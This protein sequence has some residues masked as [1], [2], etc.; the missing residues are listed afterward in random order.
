MASVAQ[1]D[2]SVATGNRALSTPCL[3]TD[4]GLRAPV[5][6]V[7]SAYVVGSLDVDE[8]DRLLRARV[9][10]WV[11]FAVMIVVAVALGRTLE[12]PHPWPMLAAML[13][14]LGGGLLQPADP[15]ARRI[16]FRGRER[17]LLVLGAG[18]ILVSVIAMFRF[19]TLE[20][21]GGG[22]LALGLLAGHT[23]RHLALRRAKR[24]QLD[25]FD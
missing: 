10:A 17:A 14:G 6:S 8:K 19:G 1:R 13:G 24:T 3:L 2:S 21:L 12:D 20:G 9:G 7:D 18:G 4:R 5:R 16:S 25:V 15:E 23:A 22:A 11:F